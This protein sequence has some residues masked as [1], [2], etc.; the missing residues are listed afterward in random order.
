MSEDLEV[1]RK[2]AGFRAS[3]R[4]TKELDWLLG[5]YADVTLNGMSDAELVR[6]ER[7]LA[8]SDPELHSWILSPEL[9]GDEQFFELLRSIRLFHG[10]SN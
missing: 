10:L 4:G 6:F 9:C 7:L 8:I 2:R 1:R 5:R 3:H